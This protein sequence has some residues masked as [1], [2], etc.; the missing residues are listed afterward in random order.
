MNDKYKYD[1]TRDAHKIF[2]QMSDIS[3]KYNDFGILSSQVLFNFKM[4]EISQ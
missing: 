1:Q 3:L 4:L 2:S